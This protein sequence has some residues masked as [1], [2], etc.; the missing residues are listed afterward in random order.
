MQF[1]KGIIKNKNKIFLKRDNF[2]CVTNKLNRTGIVH[3]N[4]NKQVDFC[5][6]KILV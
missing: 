5:F 3:N 6:F 4:V 2:T 1:S